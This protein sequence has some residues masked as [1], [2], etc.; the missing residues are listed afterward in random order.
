MM[1]SHARPCGCSPVLRL[2]KQ[3]MPWPRP[4][5]GTTTS[6]NRCIVAVILDSVYRAVLPSGP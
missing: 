2:R 1:K 6:T 4:K 3:P 5:M